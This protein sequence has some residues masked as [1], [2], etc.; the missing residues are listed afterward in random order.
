MKVRNVITNIFD[1]IK[2]NGFVEGFVTMENFKSEFM[3]LILQLFND[4]GSK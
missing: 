4:N 1:D 2:E 3:V